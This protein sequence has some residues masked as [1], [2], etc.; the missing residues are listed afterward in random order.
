MGGREWT[1][2]EKQRLREGAE[3]GEWNADIAADLSPD[4]SAYAVASQRKRMG[5]EPEHRGRF[6]ASLTRSVASG[7]EHEVFAT[8]TSEDEPIEELWDRS[9]RATSR[10]V[11]KAQTRSYALAKVVSKQ[12]IGVC[13][14]SDQHIDTSGPTDLARMKADAELIQQ[15][16]GLYCI[17]GG[18]GINNHIKHRSALVNS[19]SKPKDEWRLYNDYLGILGY[20]ILGMVSGNHDAWS[21]QFAG[22]DM[23]FHLAQSNKVHYCADEIV[24]KVMLVDSPGADAGQGYTIKVRHKYRFGSTLN[25]LHTVKRMYDMAPDPFD[26]GVVCHHH[27]A[28][29]ETFNRHGLTRYAFRPG[30]YQVASEYSRAEGFNPTRPTCPTVIL[31]PGKREIVAFE[32]VRRAVDYLAVLRG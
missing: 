22:I 19:G 32:D 10:A 15:T 16:P 24:L 9:L 28:A 5:L 4:R 30:S 25:L 18:D 2:E 31:W 14:V 13:F 23:V 20:K 12:P 26:V 1:E 6:A 8:D 11:E 3:R 21:V 17:L 7:P 27:E 29:M